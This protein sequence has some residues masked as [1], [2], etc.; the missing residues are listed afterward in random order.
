MLPSGGEEEERTCIL[1][2]LIKTERY[3]DKLCPRVEIQHR[4]MQWKK[5]L[6]IN[7]YT[8]MTHEA[9]IL[10]DNELRKSY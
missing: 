5:P 10:D 4:R 6:Q 8:L 1:S 9:V 7:N 2:R 3:Y